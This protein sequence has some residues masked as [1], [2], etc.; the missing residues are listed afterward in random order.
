[1]AKASKGTTRSVGAAK[2]VEPREAIIDAFMALAAERDIR[3][4]GL[5]DI[6]ERAGVSLADLR[7]A[8]AG[9]LGILAG[10]A[11][12]IDLAVLADGKADADSGPRDRLF[13]VMM[14]RF[15]ALEPYK[16]A[17]RRMAGS[18]RRDPGLAAV[19]HRL[20]L[21]SQ[22]WTLVA[23]DIRHSGLRGRVAIE[24]VV[25]VY[26]ET[27]KTWLKDDEPDLGRTMA[28]LDRALRRGERGM[29]ALCRVGGILPRLAE[30]GRRGRDGDSAGAAA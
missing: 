19:L 4:I 14:R 27:M 11:R 6:A 2:A 20:A 21:R 23:A 16:A 29:R 10:F 26:A 8:Y 18:A 1:M 12:R 24:G 22:R 15:D 30:R 25:L 9:K 7:A 13:E 5:D 3:D 17:V 28:T